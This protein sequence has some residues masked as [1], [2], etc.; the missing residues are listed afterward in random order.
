[1]GTSWPVLLNVFYKD[2]DYIWLRGGY[3]NRFTDIKPFMK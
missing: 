3:L 1:M 2:H